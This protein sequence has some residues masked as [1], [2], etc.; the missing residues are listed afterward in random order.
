MSWNAGA[1]VGSIEL[2][3]SKFTAG[4]SGAISGA[5]SFAASMAE[6]VEKPLEHIGELAMEAGE[7]LFDV[8]KEFA[9]HVNEMAQGA[10]RAGVSVEFFSQLA[11]V[12]ERVGVSG[13]SAGEALIFLNRNMFEAS[14]GSKEAGEGFAAL[15]I[16][17]QFIKQHLGDTEGMFGKVLGA[18]HNIPTAAERG[19]I[20]MKLFGRGGAD[21][22]PMLALSSE[23]IN[24]MVGS[25]QQFG[26]TVTTEEA[27]SAAAFR[28]LGVDFKEM[29]EGIK[30]AVAVPILGYLQQ[31]AEEIK[32]T[33]LE[34]GDIAREV[35]PPVLSLVA[36]IAGGFFEIAEGLTKADALFLKFTGNSALAAKEWKLGTQFGDLSKKALYAGVRFDQMDL[37]REAVAGP[38]VHITNNVSLPTQVDPGKVA[39]ELAK[40]M[41]PLL[42]KQ[43]REATDKIARA[44]IAR[45]MGGRGLK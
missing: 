16:S 36:Q 43:H 26:A 17:A 20:A 21:M 42:E 31:H 30:K 24:N 33:M 6:L 3:T 25:M 41:K 14:Q 19:A 38:A 8:V 22:G 18:L 2:E 27:K 39:E 44:A 32:N 13:Q 28:E 9:G 45:S 35:L 1:I 34:F 37:T 12:A 40:T 7:K 11:G 5:G 4:V 23:Q 10:D 15:G 29:W